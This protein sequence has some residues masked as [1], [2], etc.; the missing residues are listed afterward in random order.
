MDGS[1]IRAARKAKNLS[2]AT[3][4]Q[5]VGITQAYLS[6]IEANKHAN[7]TLSV[8][9]RLATELNV[10]VGDLLSR[11]VTALPLAG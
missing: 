10:P 7:V 5:R 6:L 8:L 4:S 11:E 2:Q 1:K 3:L 9:E